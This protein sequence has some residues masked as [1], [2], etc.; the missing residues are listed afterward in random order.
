MKKLVLSDLR[1]RLAL[2]VLLAV[3]PALALIFY[4]AE[5]QRRSSSLEAQQSAQRLARLVSANQEVL[6]AGTRQLLT[7]VAEVPV[8]RAGDAAA[9]SAFLQQVYGKYPYY[10]NL[11]VADIHGWVICSA[12]PLKDRVNIADRSYFWRTVERQDL[13]LGD[14]Q[15]G[16]VTGRASINIGYPL[17]D[18]RGEKAGVV[19]SGIDLTWLSR[20]AAPTRLP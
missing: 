6:I 9:C 15:V 7:A 16:R 18:R 5:E 11:A 19:I 3:T 2:L 14:Y 1:L 4:A 13:A 10:T 17:R 12:V 8:V 20:I